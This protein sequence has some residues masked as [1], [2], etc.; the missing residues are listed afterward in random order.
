LR[1]TISQA[2]AAMIQLN[3]QSEA[4]QNEVVEDGK[5][6]IAKLKEQQKKKIAQLKSDHCAI[7]ESIYTRLSAE[8]V[9][10]SSLILTPYVSQF[11]EHGRT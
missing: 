4:V 3:E 11:G 10:V 8:P 9:F 7:A 1:A 2:E 5:R 6:K